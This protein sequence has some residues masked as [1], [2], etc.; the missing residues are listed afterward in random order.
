MKRE[1]QAKT[2]LQ[3]GERGWNSGFLEKKGLS[4]K[5]T[6]CFSLAT[7]GGIEPP[8]FGLCLR[9]DRNH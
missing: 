2:G 6:P 4:V 7:G 8:I 5:A 3:V 9:E 1:K